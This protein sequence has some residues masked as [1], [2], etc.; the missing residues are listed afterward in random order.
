MIE[1]SPT[2]A[3]PNLSTFAP[4]TLF[5]ALDPQYFAI[6]ALVALFSIL[7]ACAFWGLV[8]RKLAKRKGYRGYFWTGFFLWMIGLIYV[9]GLPLS[10]EKRHADMKRL[11]Q[12]MIRAG[13]R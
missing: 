1:T 11:A 13:G 2:P 3:V 8:T 5:G 6:T 10:E 4:D 12:Y 9:V 7:L